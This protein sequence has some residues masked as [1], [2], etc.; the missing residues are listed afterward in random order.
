M[1]NGEKSTAVPETI[2]S[3]P[4]SSELRY[5]VKN[6][7]G[8]S[9]DMIGAEDA[10]GQ[11]LYY[12]GQFGHPITHITIGGVEKYR[13]FSKR[14]KWGEYH[15]GYDKD[16]PAGNGSPI[17]A[18]EIHDSNCIIGIHLNG[19]TWLP[20]TRGVKDTGYAGSMSPIDAIWI[21]R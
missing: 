9:P 12:A 13:V 11:G 15:T 16:N 4:I 3:N 14:G 17:L 19:G 21:D 18:I 7:L 5:A 2:K 1:K 20:Q 8:W 6:D 10:E